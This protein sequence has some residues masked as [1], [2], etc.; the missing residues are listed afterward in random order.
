MKNFKNSIVAKNASILMILQ[1]S[2][3][4]VPFLL[5]PYLSRVLG[6]E[7]FGELAMLWTISAYIQILID[8]GFFLWATKECAVIKEDRFALSDLWMVVLTIKSGISFLSLFIMIGASFVFSAP[9]WLY[10][11]MWLSIFAQA[12]MPSWLFQGAQKVFPLLIFSLSAQVFAAILTLICVKTADDIVFVSFSAALSWL[13]FSLAA[14]FYAYKR[15][16]LVF[17][18]PHFEAIKSALKGAWYL[19]TVNVAVAFYNNLPAFMLGVFGSR[20]EL[21]VFVGAQKIVL[22]IQGL[23]TPVSSAIFPRIAELAK[24]DTESANIFLKRAI[25]FS[26]LAMGGIALFVFIFAKEIISIVLGKEF[27]ESASL[28]RI[29]VIGPVLVAANTLIYSGYIV[30]RNLASNMKMFFLALSIAAL[31]VAILLIPA[32]KSAGA[33]ALYVGIELSVFCGLIWKIRKINNFGSG[34]GAA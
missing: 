6:L 25:G 3:Y 31:V 13:L 7:G 14:N 26:L 12:L 18:R 20:N 22:A 23:F 15:F 24:N 5:L 1:L 4:I 33:A 16:S 17:A 27:E 10:L 28:L 29:M 11:F 21:A 19:F 30:V 9:V 8:F 32:A 34:N 2:S